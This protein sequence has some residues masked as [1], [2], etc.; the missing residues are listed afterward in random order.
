MFGGGCGIFFFSFFFSH[1]IKF[2]GLTSCDSFIVCF[3]IFPVIEAE[4]IACSSWLFFFLK[5][6]KISCPF[7]RPP[8][9]PEEQRWWL[10]DDFSAFSGELPQAP[11]AYLF[12]T[13]FFPSLLRRECPAPS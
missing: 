7:C 9:V 5:D 13:L 6:M 1:F 3:S 2:P 8:R 10:G 4:L 12:L 11:P